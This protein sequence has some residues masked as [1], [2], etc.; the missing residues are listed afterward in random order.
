M[1]KIKLPSYIK[2]SSGRM[3]D[4]VFVN[5]KGVAYMRPY[6]KIKGTCTPKQAEV[7]KSFSSV[8]AD[9]K[10]LSGIIAQ[11]WER[12]VKDKPMTAVNAFMSVNMKNRRMGEPLDICLSAG[13]APLMNF[14]AAAGSGSGEITC[15]FLPP[16]TGRHITFFT[17]IVTDLD[18]R[19]VIMRHDAGEGTASPF[20]ITGLEPGVQYHVHAVVTDA[21]YDDAVTL[22][23]SVAATASAG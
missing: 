1:A 8:R 17:R 18:A 12:S 15:T 16:E 7:R 21:V 3:E 23:A 19:P 10:Y 6:R 2:E 22:S 11:T 13:E 4:E 20:T 14:S 9:W 5:W